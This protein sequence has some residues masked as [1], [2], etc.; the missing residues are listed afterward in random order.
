MPLLNDSR[1]KHAL[2]LGL[3]ATLVTAGALFAATPEKDPMEGQQPIPMMGDSFQFKPNTWARYSFK[4]AGQPSSELEFSILDEVRNRRGNAWWMEIEI[5]STDTDDVVTRVLLPETE[6]GPGDALKAIVQIEGYRPFEV[7]RKYLKPNP[8]K[9]TEQV[10]E[11]ATFTPK[12]EPQAKQFTCNGRT[13][14]GTS[15]EALDAEGR[16]VKVDL[17]PEVPPLGIVGIYGEGITT[18]ELLDWGTGA[19]TKITGKPV[20]LWR[21]VWGVAVSAAKE[22]GS[23][24]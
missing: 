20:G 15:V 16:T 21:W 8:K 18:M 19:E 13:I 5:N 12:G 3:I 10:G 24:P 17:S 7:P 14:N 23:T 1:R 4:P 22:G 11:L 2:F 6:D 9:K